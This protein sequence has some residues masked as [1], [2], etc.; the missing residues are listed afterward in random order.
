MGR[1]RP[2]RSYP[3]L[4]LLVAEKPVF[5]SRRG[6]GGD[7][8]PYTATNRVKG[9]VYVCRSPCEAFFTPDG[10]EL[11][12]AVRGEDYISI[13]D[14]ARMKEICR[15]QTANGPGMVHFRPDED[16]SRC[17]ARTASQPIFPNLA[18]SADGREAWCPLVDNANG[19]FAYITVGGLN[20]VEA[21]RR[22]P[23]PEL[24]A[25]IASG[26]VPHGIWA[27]GDGSRVYVGLQ[28]AMRFRPSTR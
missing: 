28:T 12:V 18:I 2:P 27:S 17:E 24:V 19:H 4:V 15:I 9:T 3:T 22:G 23:R 26:D 25:T 16:L 14:P 11:W 8:P 21:Y 6:A 13:L 20:Q 1:K 7:P 10:R 5:G